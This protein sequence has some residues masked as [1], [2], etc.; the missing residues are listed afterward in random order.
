MPI[1]QPRPL[2]FVNGLLR[3]NK[4]GQPILQIETIGILTLLVIARPVLSTFLTL[5]AAALLL[6][7]L[8]VDARRR[9]ARE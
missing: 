5:A 1:V 8:R 6:P 4:S 9:L 2:Q 3:E 7:G